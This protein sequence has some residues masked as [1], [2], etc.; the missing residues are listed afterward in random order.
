MSGRVCLV[1]GAS[2]GIGFGIAAEFLRRGAKVMITSRKAGNLAS[3]AESL[4]Q[5]HAGTHILTCAAHAGSGDDAERAVHMTLSEFGRLDVLVNNAATNPHFGPIM[6]MTAAQMTKT[7]TVNID[8]VALWSSVAWTAWMRDN[9]GSIVNISSI[10]AYGT[11]LNIGYY[12]ATKAAVSHLTRQLALE[13]GP[14][15]RVN[16]VAPG[17]V[18]TELSEAIV[19]AGQDRLSKLLPLGRVGM[20]ADIASA[21][22]FLAS[23][24]ASWI[25]GVTL[26]VDGGA[27]ALP[28]G[29]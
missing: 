15:V 22:A 6:A 13:M 7:A 21:V 23:D 19:G 20:P 10:G 9:G 25:T 3:A 18:L 29:I 17:P 28:S 4:A 26:P 16:G 14:N 24:D 1:T 12:N 27:L 5:E 2:R 11:D 8:S